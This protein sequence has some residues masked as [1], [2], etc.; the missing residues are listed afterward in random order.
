MSLAS[1]LDRIA[2]R[3]LAKVESRVGKLTDADIAERMP[4]AREIHR[5]ELEAHPDPRDGTMSLDVHEW[6]AM[7]IAVNLVARDR[8]YDVSRILRAQQQEQVTPR[9]RARP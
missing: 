4:E 9:D 1:E 3:Q 6:A 7:R 8:G 5:A 2:T